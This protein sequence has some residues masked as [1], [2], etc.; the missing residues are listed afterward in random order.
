M[1]LLVPN[2]GEAQMLA[3]ILGKTAPETLRLKLYSNNKTPAETDTAASYTEVTGFGY[4]AIDF[5]PADFTIVEGAPS[6]ATPT[7]K[8]F[9]FTGAA[10]LVYGYYV[11]GVT[12]NKV[13][14]CE[15]FDNTFNAQNFGDHIVVTAPF[16]LD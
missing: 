8:T 14:W 11:V 9:T 2:E 13:Y 16:G 4:S 7:A 15:R 6:I 12:S 3:V 10:G 5:A 1:S